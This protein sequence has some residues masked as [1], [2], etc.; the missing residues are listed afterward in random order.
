MRRALVGGAI[1]ELA[2]DRETSDWC[3]STPRWPR[4]GRAPTIPFRVSRVGA[5]K[6]SLARLED[7]RCSQLR[8]SGGEGTAGGACRGQSPATTPVT[9]RL[10]PGRP[11]N[12]PESC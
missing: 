10:V 11:V 9:R 1:S 7:S 12:Q 3:E 6:P 8:T 2:A 5:K 4:S